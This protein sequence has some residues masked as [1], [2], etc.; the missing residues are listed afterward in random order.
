MPH[1]FARRDPHRRV[2]FYEMMPSR[3]GRRGE[4]GEWGEGYCARTVLEFETTL[5]R[6]GPTGSL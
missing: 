2:S 5:A 1:P 3:P 6:V 4:T